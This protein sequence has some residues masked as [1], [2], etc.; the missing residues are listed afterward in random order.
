MSRKKL[1]VL[2]AVLGAITLLLIAGVIFAI[3]WLGT[4]G[5]IAWRQKYGLYNPPSAY[6]NEKP[7]IYFYPETETLIKAVFPDPGR[8]TVSYP[9]YGSGWSF[10][11]SPDGTLAAGG[12]QYPYLFYEFETD[13]GFGSCGF[14]VGREELVAFLEEKLGSMGFTEREQTDFI[15]YWLPRLSANEYNRIEFLTGEAVDELMS[16]KIDPEPQNILRVYMLFAP[17]DPG[18]ELEPQQLPKLEREGFTVL[19]WGGCAL[20]GD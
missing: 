19:E 17:C 14:A 1:T 15:T 11:A 7:V 5:G 20:P 10:T 8:M 12:R 9:E 16:L 18:L 2:I 6:Y 3:W 4:P 13:V